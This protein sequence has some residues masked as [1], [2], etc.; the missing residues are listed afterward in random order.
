MNSRTRVS[1]P[2]PKACSSPLD[3]PAGIRVTLPVSGMS[4]STCGALIEAGLAQLPG[5]AAVAVDPALERLNLT[6]DPA[7]TGLQSIRR[8]VAD[9]GFSIPAANLA[10]P[11][12]G[13]GDPAAAA[14]LQSLLADQ[15]GVLAV[16][17]D[18]AAATVALE[19][20]PGPASWPELAALIRAAGFEL[21]LAAL[22]EPPAA[23]A[24]RDGR[25][26]L[27]LG[28]G[29]LL[30]VPLVLFSMARDFG[31]AGGNHD[32]AAMLAAATLVQF[33]VGGR[34]Y[35][36][37]WHSLRAGHP[38]MDVL[39]V[40]GSS[41]AYGASLGVVLGLVPGTGVYFETS[42]AIITLVRLGR[43]LEARA[44]GRASEALRALMDLR[45]ATAQVLRDGAEHTVALEE[46]RVGDQLRVRPGAKVPVDGLICQGHSAFDEALLTG[47]AMPVSK[48][49]GAEVIGGTL[50]REG[51]ITMAATRVG[52]STALA[53]IVAVVQQAQASKAPI[54]KRAD[55]IGRVFVPIVLA[56]GVLTFL[57]WI[58]VAQLPWPAALLNAI[59]VLVI[60]CPCAIGLATPTAILVGTSRGAEHGLLFKTSEALERAGKVNLVVL[61]KT[62]TLTL[63]AIELAEIVPL[64]GIAGSELLRLAAS[65]EQGS[66]HPFG[67][68]LAEAG[69]ARGLTLA[70]P[71]AFRAFGGLGVDARVEGRRVLVGNQRLLRNQGL[72]LEPLRMQLE[73][74]QAEGRTAILVAADDADRPLCPLGLFALADPVKPEAREAIAELRRQGLDVMMLT[75]DHLRTAEAIARQLGISQV[76]AEVLPEDKAAVIRRLQARVPG[77]GL[78]LP[79]VAMVG[80]GI[81]DAPALAQA[82]VGIALGTGTDVAMATAGITLIGGNL[83]GVAR[84][85]ALSRDTV[86]TIIQNLVW[87][88]CYN[89]VLI[90]IAAYGLLSPM[91]AAG[92]MAFS[93]LFVVSNS[94]RLRGFSLDRAQQSPF[95]QGLALIP[96]VLAPA[97]ALLL[98]VSMPM[99][100][101]QGGAGIQGTLPGRMSPNLMMVMAIAN[102][103]IVVSYAS[104]PVFLLVFLNRR[105]DIPF[106]GLILLFGA[107]ILACSVTHFTHILGLW[108]VTDWWQ[109]LVDSVCALISLATAILV[110]PLLPQILAIPSPQQ[111]QIVNRELVQEKAELE[112]TQARL[113]L[114]YEEVEQRVQERT[115]E[116]HLEV[117]ERVRLHNQLVQSQKMESLGNLAGG[118]A[119]DMNNVLGAILGLASAHLRIQPEGSPAH[120]AFET[121]ATAAQ[122]GGKMVRGLLG[123]ARQ[124]LPEELE[125]DVNGV[126]SEEVRLL[127]R[128][129]L[130]RIRLVLDL[131]PDLLRIRGDASAL[132]HAFMNLCVNAVDA[133]AEGGTL[134]LRTRNLEAGW[135]EVEVQDNG[136]GMAREVLDR[137]LDPFYTTKGP[138]K[139]TGLGLSMVYG[140]V[141]AHRGELEILSEPGQGTRV[142]MRFPG[143]AAAAAVPEG[144]TATAAGTAPK[145]LSVL[146]VDDDTLVLRSMKTVL[147]LL[148]HQVNAVPSGEEA[149]AALEGG[150]RPEVVILD[151][152]MPGLGGAG[153]LPLLRTL[154]PTTPVLLATGRT[155][156]TALDLVAAHA[157]VILMAKPFSMEELQ[158]QLEDLG[159]A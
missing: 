10:L 117:E 130:A 70:Q 99:F 69:R 67:R 17:V 76:L 97:A 35:R 133:M 47:E 34:F 15:P 57:G 150:L 85:I 23:P 18:P 83:L 126:L 90:P 43:H 60:A 38:G 131:A 73:R 78:P 26:Q 125:L 3:P 46:V 96:R 107:F 79:V 41:A 123:F 66:E 7:H 40:L 33:L 89:I 144:A 32:L 152:N 28:L 81:N 24:G 44:K 139:G 2:D 135:I 20:I 118:V 129:T 109:A 11:V 39:V 128:T 116:L 134:T 113:R 55:Q 84:A 63:G 75:G 115:R 154:A 13:L 65:A 149:L 100:A 111:L 48:G 101:M 146:L 141:K 42:A 159:G 138:G 86:Q 12:L 137:A 64:A 148:G 14:R 153:T 105:K 94:L 74:I 136:S 156:Q 22:P 58:T 49:P 132:S 82:D 1:A 71:Q 142:R 140:A 4:C 25:D 122:R 112:A 50:N 124:T 30:T 103:L 37:A 36:S 158:R 93:S 5:I 127:E 72:D 8:A 95:R 45:P 80:D 110:W 102:G 92:A 147:E 114:A 87:A 62:G 121:I 77:P 52:R 54:Q 91:F 31:L 119:H 143:L 53:Q 27:L 98:L 68:A 106:S 6:Y 88:F 29:L 151:M 59:A 104:I 19:F 155:D 61:D 145:E 157:H 51:F 16:T 21:A 56:L 9:L 120:Q 108:L